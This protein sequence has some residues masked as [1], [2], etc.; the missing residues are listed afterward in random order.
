MKL[1]SIILSIAIAISDAAASSSTSSASSSTSSSSSDEDATQGCPCNIAGSLFRNFVNGDA[2]YNSTGDGGCEHGGWERTNPT[3]PNIIGIYFGAT[4]DRD[5]RSNGVGIG[6]GYHDS[7]LYACRSGGSYSDDSLYNDTLTSAEATACYDL[8][9]DA[10]DPSDLSA[11][12]IACGTTNVPYSRIF[13]DLYSDNGKDLELFDLMEGDERRRHLTTY[14]ENKFSTSSLGLCDYTKSKLHGKT[15]THEQ[16]FKE[17]NEVPATEEE[18]DLTNYE[19]WVV[20][21]SDKAVLLAPNPGIWTIENFLNEEEMDRLELLVTKYGNEHGL[22]G[23]HCKNSQETSNAHPI[24]GKHCFKMS[25]DQVCGGP[26]DLSTCE[27]DPEPED[28]DFIADIHARF[29]SL[30]PTL[31]EATPHAKFQLS[32][33]GTPPVD[34]HAD[35]EK[36]VSFVL[37]FGDG[38]ASM[39]F[40]NANARVT[41]KRGTAH[42]WIN[43]FDDQSTRN[44]ASDHAVQAHSASADERLV[45]LF[46]IPTLAFRLESAYGDMA[47]SIF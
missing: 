40:P 22:F 18:R 23:N 37:Y 36:I 20:P 6:G 11:C 47:H 8:L 42:T 24:E 21:S 27:V 19:P 45:M 33:G 28:S 44:P 39:I 34:L 1:G 10:M 25:V 13:R 46:D 9:V 26:Y 3:T 29:E 32:S 43:T 14:E 7:G 38:G 5:Y 35:T 12:G 2:M 4:D 15:V 41:P 31:P 30:W 17:V 16:C